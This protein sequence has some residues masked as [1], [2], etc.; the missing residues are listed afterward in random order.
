MAS[1]MTMR[2]G[3]MTRRTEARARSRRISFMA[4]RLSDSRLTSANTASEGMGMSK[5]ERASGRATARICFSHGKTFSSH[6]RETSGK[7]SR[8][9]VSPVGAQ[10]TMTTSHSP[11]AWARLSCSSA[12]SSSIPGG[13]VSS[14]AEI[15]STPRS[16]SSS[17]SQLW[18][19]DQCSSISAWDS[20]CWACSPPATGVGAGPTSSSSASAR[21]WA[22]SVDMTSVRRPAAAQARAVLAATD[23]LPTPPLPV[24]RIVRGAIDGRLPEVARELQGRAAVD[25]R[26]RAVAQALEEVAQQLVVGRRGQHSRRVVRPGAGVETRSLD[27]GLAV[28]LAEQPAGQGVVAVVPEVPEAVQRLDERVEDLQVGRE[29]VDRVVVAASGRDGHAD[30]RALAEDPERL[31]RGAQ[32]ARAVE[33]GRGP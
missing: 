11:L 30:G 29:G 33:P 4:M 13:T 5:T 2:S 25:A 10:S 6:Q 3:F 8:R 1:P 27:P 22:G 21:E 28:A 20:T 12:N 14:S 31:V 15:R 23:V 24:Y 19:A 32:Q 18:T 17:P 7:E 16:M 26:A 9:S